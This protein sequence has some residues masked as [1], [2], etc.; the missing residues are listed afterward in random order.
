MN[1]SYVILLLLLPM[2]LGAQ[3][4]NDG[5]M[6]P[7]DETWEDPEY[8]I[9][10]HPEFGFGGLLG[11]VTIDGSSYTQFRFLP[12]LALW[13]LGIGMDID[14]LVDSQGQIRREGWEDPD[15]ILRRVLYLRFA[16][17][18]D[19]LYFRIGS[20]P[21]YTLGHGLIFDDYSNM[22]RY[23]EVK[24]TGAY[25]GV[26]TNSYGFSFEAYTHDIGQN[27]ILAGRAS[28]KPLQ[29]LGIRLLN[30]LRVGVNLGADRN[31]RGKYPDTD[32]DGFPDVYD[33]FPGDAGKWLDSD[34]D[35]LAD[36]VDL[37][38]NGNGVIDHPDLNPYVQQVFPDIDQIYPNYPFD[39]QLSPDEALRYAEADAIWISSADYELPV[40][41]GRD[42]Y[43][44]HYGE[45]A[46]MNNEGRGL[47]FPGFA[48]HW[49]ILDAK[50]EL[51]NF[52]D[53]FLPAYFNNLYDEQRCEV[54][55]D[56]AAGEDGHRRYSLRT[57]A[58]LLDEARGGLGWFGYLKAN[59]FNLGYVKLAYQDMY[60]TE[61]RFGKSVWG[62]L[63]LIP[64]KF[65]KLK[66]AS[67]YYAQTD[68]NR[69]ELDKLRCEGARLAGRVVWG[70]TDQYSLVGRY[71]EFYTDLNGDGKIAGASETVETLSF[72]LEFQF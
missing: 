43:I 58:E 66:E 35:G 37:D 26:N 16:D 60:N 19:S 63:T 10:A 24:A 38:L 68:V 62:K 51:R 7:G 27:Q 61:N 56:P 3:S 12:E 48:L 71:Q 1:R 25:I 34:D 52:S 47:I 59:L 55:I 45:L 31:P 50:F 14:L 39:L 44:S 5:Y 13:K 21:D 64:Q 15:D 42:F 17:R 40:I 70:Y 30:R 28:L 67:L 9:L 72:G 41:A 20:I 2:I 53:N 8:E 54:V 18:T 46:A 36:N 29:A 33:K 22:L 4:L 32:H 65:P 23:P 69:I 6:F 11:T 57:K 49:T